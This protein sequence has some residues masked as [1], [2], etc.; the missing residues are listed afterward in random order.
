MSGATLSHGRSGRLPLGALRRFGLLAAL[1]AV[2][3]FFG[4]T[5]PTFLAPANLIGV[6]VNNFALLAIVSVA[7]TLAVN[8]GGIDLSVGTAVDLGSLAFV[9][10]IVAGLPVGVAIVLG[11]AA[12]AATGL[13]NAA[14]I[15][16]LRIT[17]FL[18]TLG[19]LFIGRSLQQLAA[20]GGNPVYV[21]AGAQPP[22]LTLI[23]HGAVAGVPISLW[24]IAVIAIVFT[25][26]LT[27]T[28][29]GREAAAVGVQ[30][31][32]AIFSG[33]PVGRVRALVYVFGG[34]VSA[35]AGIL[36]SSSVAAYVPYSGNAFLL[37]AIGA[38]FIGTTVSRSGRANVPGTL[39]GVLLL[40]LVGNGLLLI[41]WNFYWQQVGQGV[42]IFLA[43]AF[44]FAGRAEGR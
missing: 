1:V 13:F 30:P 24:L 34:V 39:V 36:L 28:R 16:A 32:V 15:S 37:N 3:A 35:S 21:P 2:I 29:F 40:A 23:G 8:S 20:D 43:L 4:L 7:M 5:T 17:P 31:S 33:L 19:T 6:L 41:G 22:A 44:C 11:L 42:L 25:V 26:I 38:T 14:L 9:T 12:G 18:A 27:R 10:A